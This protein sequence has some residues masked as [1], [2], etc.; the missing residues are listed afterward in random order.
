[1]NRLPQ[2][3]QTLSD[4]INAVLPQTQCTRCGY[5]ACKPYADAIA[6]GQA[7]IN[8][9]PPGGDAGIRKLAEITARP[10][11][12]LNPANGIESPR[13]LAWVD[14]ERCIGCT[15][16]IA[17]CP[18]DAIVGGF[19]YMHT[20]IADD[21]TG[22]ELCIAPCPVDCIEMHDIDG[23]AEWTTIH[24]ARSRHLFEIRIQRL[25]N[26]RALKEKPPAS[27]DK[28]ADVLRRARERAAKRTENRADQSGT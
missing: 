24:A 25:E 26:I 18:V 4:A 2:K 8:Q 7:N 28:L 17:A 12:P 9:C 19:K 5:P 15:L 6:Q 22:C 13:K 11:Q 27:A 3:S 10:Y 14:E 23:P 21:C 16:C 1:M 20:V